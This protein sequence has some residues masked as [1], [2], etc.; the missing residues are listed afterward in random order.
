MPHIYGSISDNGLN[1]DTNDNIFIRTP[2]HSP[3]GSIVGGG[4]SNS[5]AI[6][7]ENDSLV[8]DMYYHQ[9]V[10][11]IIKLEHLKVTN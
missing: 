3:T 2:G 8:L 10:M 9:N 6:L 5:S 7:S 1:V 4:N 11:L